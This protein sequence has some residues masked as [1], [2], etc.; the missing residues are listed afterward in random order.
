MTPTASPPVEKKSWAAPTI[1]R[2]ASREALGTGRLYTDS[3][4]GS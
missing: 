3:F 1:R 4:Y 2:I